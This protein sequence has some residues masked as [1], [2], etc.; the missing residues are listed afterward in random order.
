MKTSIFRADDL[1]YSEAVNHGIKK[2]V[3]DGWINN[4]GV[5]VNMPHAAHGIELLKDTDICLGLH[6]NISNGFPLIQADKIPSLCNQQNFKSSK[7]YRH[8]KGDFVDVEEAL[9]EVEAQIDR[10][11]ELTNKTPSYL[12]V[13]AVQSE[14]FKKAVHTVSVKRGIQFIDVEQTLYVNHKI[15][16]VFIDEGKSVDDTINSLKEITNQ[17]ETIP[18]IVFHPGFIDYDLYKQSSLLEPRFMQVEALC[19]SELK[20]YLVEHNIELLRFDELSF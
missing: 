12:D 6:V 4:V 11:L 3:V 5:M 14:N 20:N 13:H 10:F 8:A 18:L 19:S 16:T 15:V 9:L 1:G 2:A 17:T 7:E